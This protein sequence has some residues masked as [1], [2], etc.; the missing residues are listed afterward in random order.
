MRL[1]Y[2]SIST[3][4]NCPLAYKFRYVD[5]LPT[6]RTPQLSYG[7]S[8]H[9]ILAYFYDVPHA[10]PCSL[11]HL[12][13]HFPNVWESQGY[14]DSSEEQTYFEHAKEVLAQ[15]YH[16][17]V[18]NFQ[19][20]IA[21]EHK[22][23][24]ELTSCTL[25]GIIDRV[26]QLPSGSYEIIDYKTNRKLPPESKI[27]NDLQ[28]SIYHLACKEVW[29]AEPDKLSLYFLIPNQKI[30]TRRSVN[31][32]Q[33]TKSIIAKV[34]KDIEAERF[35]PRENSLCPWCDFQAYCPHHKHEFP[36][37]EITFST[38]GSVEDALDIEN[39]VN[40]FISIREKAKDLS[41]H[42]SELKQVIHSYFE[43]KNASYI[44]SAKG[45]VFRNKRVTQTYNV[46]K[47]RQ[48][49]QPQGLWEHIT[50]VDST[51]LKQLINSED[52]SEELKMQIQSAV[53]SEEINYTLHV[54]E[55]KPIKQQN[56]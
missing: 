16:T 45:A 38:E 22:F 39:V 43:T 13:E 47:L 11:N 52:S 26:D 6:K 36:E 12:L 15:F 8:L 19:I 10:K 24:I 37:Q 51:L 21:L 2:S 27:H 30:S 29:G 55:S 34:C 54:K 9:A 41:A 53:E 56:G 25:T 31:D 1:S 7:S 17:N 3:Y 18:E 35:Q 46:D 5:K 48:I 33:K 20:P 28:L 44:H 40:E 4:Q 42:L 49:L 23:Q 32:I 14:E 50:T